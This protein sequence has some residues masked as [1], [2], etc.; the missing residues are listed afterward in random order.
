LQ[1]VMDYAFFL[2]NLSAR[3]LVS[4]ARFVFGS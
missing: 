3:F 1:F 4:E 2:I